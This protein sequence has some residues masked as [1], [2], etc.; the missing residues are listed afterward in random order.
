MKYIVRVKSNI[1][2]DGRGI[3]R[4]LVDRQ[5]GIWGD[6]KMAKRFDTHEAAAKA[7][8]DAPPHWTVI[9]EEV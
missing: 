9:I 2:H 8:S 4:Y 1:G 5:N 3:D 6:Q 7:L